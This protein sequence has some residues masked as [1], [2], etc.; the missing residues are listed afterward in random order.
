VGKRR[1]G[2][3]DRCKIRQQKHKSRKEKTM[4]IGG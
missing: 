1:K 2:R 4:K 3:K